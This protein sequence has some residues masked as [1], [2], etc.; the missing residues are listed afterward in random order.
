MVIIDYRAHA[1]EYQDKAVREI[2]RSRADALHADRQYR[3]ARN[4][5]NQASWL[6]RNPELW[7]V[8]ITPA[9]PEQMAS[10]AERIADMYL[11]SAFK[12]EDKA[13]FYRRLAKDNDTLAAVRE[14]RISTLTTEES[15]RS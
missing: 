8:Y 11:V 1:A 10:S 4:Y 3:I 14:A 12:H 7:N 9:G 5:R 13:V 2:R 15:K 6:T